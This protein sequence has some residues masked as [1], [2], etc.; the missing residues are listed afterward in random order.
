MAQNNNRIEP[1]GEDNTGAAGGDAVGDANADA[2][3]GKLAGL[4]GSGLQISQMGTM[5]GGGLIAAVI[6][7]FVYPLLHWAAPNT[8][9]PEKPAAATLVSAANVMPANPNAGQNGGGRSSRPG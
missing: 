7:Y 5:L 8:M 2:N 1:E 6:G 9:P 3:R 4:N